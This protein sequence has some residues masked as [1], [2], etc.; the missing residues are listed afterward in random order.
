MDP[1]ADESFLAANSQPHSNG[2][3]R[4]GRALGAT[5]MSNVVGGAGALPSEA[6]VAPK[7]APPLTRLV[8]SLT[9]AFSA[10][11][12][13]VGNAIGH[14]MEG[15]VTTPAAPRAPE[16]S[17]L[18]TFKSAVGFGGHS[19]ASAELSTVTGAAP[20]TRFIEGRTYTDAKG[21]KAKYQAGQWMPVD[22]A[23]V[24]PADQKTASDA[25]G[26]VTREQA[27]ALPSGTLF[28]TMDGRLL[29]RH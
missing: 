17:L 11:S 5:D 27:L 25:V 23:G 20:S 22:P 21:R 29:R 9:D 12:T 24:N 26:P 15:P 13:S 2:W 10:A 8:S 16:P 6:P 18:D 19:S 28:T 3:A 7:K 14:V 1:F 4:L